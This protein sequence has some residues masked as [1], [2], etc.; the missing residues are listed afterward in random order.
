[1]EFAEWWWRNCLSERQCGCQRLR[2]SR[3]HTG[4]RSDVC[5]R[6]RSLSNKDRR[7][8]AKYTSSLTNG[9]YCYHVCV[10]CTVL[11]FGL[12][13]SAGAAVSWS[14]AGLSVCVCV[15]LSECY[16]ALNVLLCADVPLRT[17]THSECSSVNTAQRDFWP[18]CKSMHA[19]SQVPTTL[20]HILDLE[21][22]YSENV[23]AYHKWSLYVNAS[24]SSSRSRTDAERE[25]CHERITK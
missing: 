21:L 4:T 13:I 10:V 11:S 18:V 12:F 19:R 1:M 14:V 24:E 25:R 23:W 15:C 3:W 20:I 7:S 6:R 8:S 16:L 22:R 2:H 17:Y 9:L 5:C